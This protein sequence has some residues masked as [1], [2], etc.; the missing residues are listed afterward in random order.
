M[1]LFAP[2]PPRIGIT[3]ETPDG[4]IN[5]SVE[6]WR[7]V[8]D[9]QNRA[10]IHE[11]GEA[12]VNVAHLSP[13]IFAS[14]DYGATLENSGYET[15]LVGSTMSQYVRAGV[16]EKLLKAQ[17][18]L[19]EGYKLIVFDGWR[20]IDTQVAAFTLCYDSLVARLRSVG[21]LA[22]STAL[23]E[24]QEALIIEE[25]TRYISIPSPLP[26]A[27]RPSFLR[28]T[29]DSPAPSPHTTG[30]SVD[31]GIVS[32]PPDYLE[33]VAQLEA[34]LA[35]LNDPF[36]PE[37]TELLLRITHLYRM[38]AKLLDFGSAFDFAGEQSGLRYFETSDHPARNN[39]RMLYHVMTQAGFEAYSEEWWHFN[40][41]NQMAAM[42]TWRRTGRRQSAI[43]GPAALTPEQLE[44]EQ[45]WRDLATALTHASNS[46][47][48][49]LTERLT[50]HGIDIH[51]IEQLSHIVGDPRRV[52]GLPPSH[53]MQYRGEVPQALIDALRLA[54]SAAL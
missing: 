54:G 3:P 2:I 15:A 44:Y 41:G 49:K 27:N 26:E 28:N 37:Y 47:P 8:I 35:H 16:A 14:N 52:Q 9:P 36:S 19:P 13:F 31:V 12:L 42:T 20:S 17:E 40:M 21:A 4:W 38:H 33:E 30:G 29:L 10:E 6:D 45:F 51:Y 46:Q 1:S 50:Q 34:S 18:L 22:E 43:Y 23:T 39:R 25:V 11:S 24:P 5:G 48:V 7:G 53:D 32:I